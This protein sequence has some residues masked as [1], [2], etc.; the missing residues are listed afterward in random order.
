MTLTATITQQ[1][2]ASLVIGN[3]NDFCPLLAFDS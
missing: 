3:F 2:T 1:F